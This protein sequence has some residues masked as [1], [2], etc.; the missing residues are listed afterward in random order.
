MAFAT[1]GF[2]PKINSTLSPGTGYCMAQRSMQFQIP[3]DYKIIQSRHPLRCNA[4]K[5]LIHIISENK[6]QIAIWRQSD[7]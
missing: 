5:Q 1:C 2:S 7:L 4:Q 6:N 3:A